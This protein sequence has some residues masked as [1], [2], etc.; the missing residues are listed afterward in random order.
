MRHDDD[1]RFAL[2][3]ALLAPAVSPQD[4]I[5]KLPI[6]GVA[7]YERR[8]ERFACHEDA[9][10]PKGVVVA[11][12]TAAEGG[13]MWRYTLQAPPAD[14]TKPDFDDSAWQV[15]RSGF[16]NDADHDDVR[17]PWHG[18]PSTIWL[19]TTAAGTRSQPRAAVLTLRHDDTIAVHINGQLVHEQAQYRPSYAAVPLDRDA[20]RAL[21]AENVLAVV[22]GNVG[23]AQYI[24]VGLRLYA[25]RAGAD[26]EIPQ[27]EAERKAR[28]RRHELFPLLRRPPLLFEGMLDAG[29]Q[30]VEQTPV[31]LRDL[32]PW[33]A[34]DLR[35]GGRAQTRRLVVPRVLSFGDLALSI[36]SSA[37]AADGSQSLVLQIQSRTPEPG[38][39]GRRFL[40][41]FVLPKSAWEL[42]GELRIE[43]VHDARAGVARSFAARLE[44]TATRFDG[45]GR[46]LLIDLDERWTLQRVR[47]NR[48]AEFRAA[49]R[50]ALDRNARF[51]RNDLADLT[52]KH[53]AGNPVDHPSKS[54][55]S[56]RLAMGLMALVKAGIPLDDPVVA[57]CRE[58]LRKREIVDSYSLGNAAMAVEACYAP[59]N[60]RDELHSGLIAAPRP[61]EPLPE[62]R[63][64]LQRWVEQI[65]ANRDASTD[66]AYL[67][68][69]HYTPGHSYDNSTTQYGLLGLYAA[70]L[71]GIRQAATVWRAAAE[72]LLADQVPEDA[73]HKLHLTGEQAFRAL[74]DGVPPTGERVK[75]AG[76]GYRGVENGAPP[77]VRGSMTAAGIAGLTMCRAA[78]LDLGVTPRDRTLVR[79]DAAIDSGFAWLAE[80]F[81][82]TTNPNDIQHGYLW[83]YYYLY[84]LERACELCDVTLI[85]RRDWYFEGAMTLMAWMRPSGELMAEEWGYRDQ[86][87]HAIERTAFCALFLA[88]AALPVLTKK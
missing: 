22:C 78:L 48:D 62:D 82:V 24:D 28:N 38:P 45:T 63:Q 49:V 74:G 76:W 46:P 16:G 54:A 70:R 30:F 12:P 42:R 27:G 6:R 39:E 60:E 53:L 19:R 31:E 4:P 23:G 85:G 55:N 21:R 64:A 44:G 75:V 58:E 47:A 43:R 77:N 52:R 72:H 40:Q 17:T 56:G 2:V 41:S 36:K 5:W 69:F 84:A 15:G 18:A 73:V 1:V 29:A 66:P 10:Q 68:R 20:L 81:D 50:D 26:A 59:A 9:P 34:F 65:F 11:L 14:W 13:A 83:R 80:H 86:Y 79:I 88:K 33:A 51:L 35:D 57:A 61:R 8:V 25:G 87:G 7:E 37:L 32:L 3:L 71:C 67:L